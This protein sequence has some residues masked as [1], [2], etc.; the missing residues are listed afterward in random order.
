MSTTID[1]NSRPVAGLV[2]RTVRRLACLLARHKY[3]VARQMNPPRVRWCVTA[4][5]APGACTTRRAPL[6]RGMPSLRLPMR[7]ADRWTRRTTRADA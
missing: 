4:A 3:R 7:L 1:P 2:E 5:D 6:C